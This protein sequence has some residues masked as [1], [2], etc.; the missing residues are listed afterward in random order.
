VKWKNYDNRAG[1][2]YTTGTLTEWLPLLARE[3]IRRALYYEIKLAMRRYGVSLG[4]VRE[5][6]GRCPADDSSGGADTSCP[7]LSQDLECGLNKQSAATEASAR[8]EA[9][10]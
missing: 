8:S 9:G 3:D 10:G 1:Y 5:G 6:P 2:Y 7:P 4:L